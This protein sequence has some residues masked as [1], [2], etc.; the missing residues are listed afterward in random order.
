MKHILPIAMTSFIFLA[1]CGTPEKSNEDNIQESALSEESRNLNLLEQEL[2]EITEKE[3]ELI[4]LSRDDF[5]RLLNEL[6]KSDKDGSQITSEI[7]KNQEEITVIL[8]NT[9][10][11]SLENL[12]TAPYFDTVIRKMYVNSA[13]YENR[14]PVI[15]VMDLNGTVLAEYENVM[16]ASGVDLE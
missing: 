16:D 2:H 11:E 6:S 3:W 14:Q 1:A 12:F 4:H 15:K 5:D 8:N 13:Y 9:D 7:R 10:G